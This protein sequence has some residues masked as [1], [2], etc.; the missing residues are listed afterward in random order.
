[1]TFPEV[2]FQRI[3][4]VGSFV[5]PERSWPAFESRLPLRPTLAGLFVA[6]V[7]VGL[8]YGLR[9]LQGTLIQVSPEPEESARTTGATIGGTWRDVV[10]PTVRPG[11][12]GA[13][14]LIM[15]IFL[16]RGRRSR[17]GSRCPWRADRDFGQR[18]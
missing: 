15:I 6:Y 12:A 1:M 16:R 4:C 18:G 3:V 14:A 9:L 8:S 10:V 11:P 5:S 13:W 2:S 7:V 17:R